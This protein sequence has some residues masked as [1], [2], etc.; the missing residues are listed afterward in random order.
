MAAREGGG[1]AEDLQLNTPG[2]GEDA[3][4][5]VGNEGCGWP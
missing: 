3:G 5:A 2:S 1:L 4:D